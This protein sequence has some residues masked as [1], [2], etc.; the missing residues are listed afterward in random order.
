MKFPTDINCTAS[1]A[2]TVSVVIRCRVILE[3]TVA[4]LTEVVLDCWQ[5]MSLYDVYASLL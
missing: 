1:S 5:Q 4:G 2:H 3:N